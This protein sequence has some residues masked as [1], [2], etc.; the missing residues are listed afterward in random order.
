MFRFSKALQTTSLRTYATG[1]EIKY[2]HKA[3]Q[4]MLRGVEQTA[5]AVSTTM[6]PKGRN[7]IIQQPYGAPK[8]TKDGVT[9]ARSI[10]FSDNGLN[11]GAQLVRQ[12]A[13][14]T[15]DIAGDGTTTAS[16]LTYAILQEGLMKVA[17]GLNPMDLKRGI[18][19]ATKIAV[20]SLLN[21]SK[22]I[23]SKEEITQ[24]ATISANGDLEIGSLI[25]NAM[26][27]VGKEGV[28]TVEEGKT[29]DN[30]L[31]LVEGLKF[32]RGYISAYFVSDTKS[33]KCVMEKPLILIADSKISNMNDMVGVLQ[34]VLKKNNRPLLVIAEDVEGEALATLIVNKLRTGAKVCA[35]KAPGFGDHRKNNLQDISV[36]TGGTLVSE[37]LGLKLEGVQE[38][39]LGSAE[40]VIVSKDDTVILNGQGEK[41]SIEERCEQLRELLKNPDLS[42]FESE[43]LQER[44]AKLSGGVAVL[45]IG[46]A[47]EVEVGE[48]KDRVTDA[49]NATR[50]A[51]SEGI[52][53][54]GGT[55]L[56]R[57]S[58]ELNDTE[59]DNFDQKVGVEIVQ[60][61][62]RM[63]LKTI[64]SNAGKEGAVIVEK[65]LEMNDP[66]FGYNAATDKFEDLFKAGVI[67]PTKVVKTALTS[68]A[69]IGSLMITSESMVIDEPRDEPQG[70]Q[71]NMGA[72]GGMDGMF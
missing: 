13:S 52:V 10:E 26:E 39:W 70:A 30:Q 59:T 54:G 33:Q 22:S 24:V 19:K 32:D 17:A 29:L 60:K 40:K 7:V 27:K 61:A 47:S 35:V 63:P 62:L 68:S 14:K 42:E 23:T 66:S 8:I 15:N 11:T 57:A 21:Q 46:G 56:L 43:K 69:S 64:A 20:Q 16:V 31:D 72:M 3:R 25:S 5:K 53:A 49:L 50:A 34:L 48:K 41:E 65:V 58:M 45:K 51:V 1:K 6:G 4:L 18:D 28:I 2:G 44:L 55:A 9:V 12:V 67:D 37:D 38:S 71:P 36:V